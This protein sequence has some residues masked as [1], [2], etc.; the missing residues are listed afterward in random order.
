[1]ALFLMRLLEYLGV[2]APAAV[3]DGLPA[4]Y[5]AIPDYAR[6][7]VELRARK[8]ARR[9]RAGV[10]SEPSFPVGTKRGRRNAD[11]NIL[12]RVTP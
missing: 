7:A 5:D 4:D 12:R 1:M 2:D 10:L 11:K 3:T 9:G 6:E 8:R